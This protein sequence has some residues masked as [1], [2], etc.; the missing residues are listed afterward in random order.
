ME[1]NNKAKKK[2]TVLVIVQKSASRHNNGTSKQKST[3]GRKAET[4]K[5]K[6]HSQCQSKAQSTELVKDTSK[7]VVN[8]VLNL[9]Q[10]VTGQKI[11]KIV[12]T[13]RQQ[14]KVINLI[15]QHLRVQ[16]L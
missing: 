3:P 16:T 1:S 8:R 14:P 4:E 5:V 9:N 13:C 15:I 11:S 6:E 10:Y 7:K 12:L 2:Q